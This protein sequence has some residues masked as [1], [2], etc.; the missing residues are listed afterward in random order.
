MLF[1]YK[2]GTVRIIQQPDKVLLIYTGPSTDVRRVRLNDR[3]PEPLSRAAVVGLQV[4]VGV[5]GVHGH[6]WVDA[7]GVLH[8]L[9]ERTSVF[10][11]T[12]TPLN[13]RERSAILVRSVDS[14]GGTQIREKS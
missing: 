9:R 4:V 1:I 14:A 2:Q 12:A 5:C 6:A 7:L 13:A 11:N 8:L 10:A 3:H